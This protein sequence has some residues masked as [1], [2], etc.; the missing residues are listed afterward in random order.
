MAAMFCGTT[1]P[2]ML[3]TWQKNITAAGLWTYVEE[4]ASVFAHVVHQVMNKPPA[5]FILR[6]FHNWCLS[7]KYMPAE[8]MYC[9]GRLA[10]NR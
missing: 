8:T 1:L 6:V 5:G 10:I 3:C 4:K 2:I 7:M 9:P